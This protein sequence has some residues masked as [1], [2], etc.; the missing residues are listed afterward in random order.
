MDIVWL[1]IA[2]AGFYFAST[3]FMTSECDL[4]LY[5]LEFG[6]GAATILIELPVIFSKSW[7]F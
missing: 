6:R 1:Y 3:A 4:W 5:A 2:V 7:T